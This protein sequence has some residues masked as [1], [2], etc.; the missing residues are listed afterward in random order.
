MIIR[1]KVVDGPNSFTIIF[2]E[3]MTRFTVP[4]RYTWQR[5]LV[6]S[7]YLNDCE[8]TLDTS[9]TSLV[10]GTETYYNATFDTSDVIIDFNITQLK[11]VVHGRIL[12]IHNM[13]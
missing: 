5:T 4:M 12:L 1:S 11:T 7:I 13:K 10:M 8:T 2:D 6:P 9:V 3:E